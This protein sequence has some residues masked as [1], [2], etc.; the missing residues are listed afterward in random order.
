MGRSAFTG[1][2]SAGFFLALCASQSFA[3]ERCKRLEELNGNMLAC[4]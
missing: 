1:L 2:V 3:D 4:S